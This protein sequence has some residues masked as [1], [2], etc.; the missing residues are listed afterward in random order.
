MNRFNAGDICRVFDG[1]QGRL[2]HKPA[3]FARLPVN[4][5]RQLYRLLRGGAEFNLLWIEISALDDMAVKVAQPSRFN[6]CIEKHFDVITLAAA[7]G[8][9]DPVGWDPQGFQFRNDTSD[10]IRISVVH[11]KADKPAAVVVGIDS[12]GIFML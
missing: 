4:G 5:Q 10:C 2:I 11:I 7:E 1:L 12:N 8:D 3:D 6:D 9:I